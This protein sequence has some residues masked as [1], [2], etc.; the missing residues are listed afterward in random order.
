MK[1]SILIPCYNEEN[2][3][4]KVIDGIPFAILTKLGYEVEVIVIN[5]NSTDKTAAVA[6]RKKA[7][8]IFEPNLGKGNAI[9]AGFNAIADDTS[10]VVMLD[11]DNTYVAN[12]IPRI[13]EP[14]ASGFSDVIIGSRLGGKVKKGSL[15]FF[16]RVYNW[17]CIFLVRQICRVNTTDVLSGYFGWRKEVIDKLKPHITS[18]GFAIEMEMM[19]KIAKMGYEIYAVPITYNHREGKSKINPILDSL[20][21]LIMFFESLFWSPKYGGFKPVVTIRKAYARN[22]ILKNSRQLKKIKLSR[23][24][25]VNLAQKH[26]VGYKTQK[27]LSAS[28]TSRNLAVHYA[29]PR[30]RQLASRQVAYIGSN[31]FATT[32]TSLQSTDYP[33]AQQKHRQNEPF[34]GKINLEKNPNYPAVPTGE[35]PKE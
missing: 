22:N 12:E 32:L 1:I 21:I 25:N 31:N 35:T 23:L 7:H 20:R 13:I 18:K 8:V 15:R 9:R 34:P 14:L 17:I 19:M 26:A 27:N 2:G 30:S 6:K 3:V 24:S 4:G 5:N 10:F 16:N 11:G 29:K 28:P 33:A